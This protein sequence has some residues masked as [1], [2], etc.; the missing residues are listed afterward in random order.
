MATKNDVTQEELKKK[1]IYYPEEGYFIW[2]KLGNV[3]GWTRKD[4]YSFIRLNNKLYRTHRL[5]W[6]YMYGSF[7]K[8]EIDHIDGNPNNNR[9]NNLRL[10]NSTQNKC[11]TRL[12]KDSTSGAKGIH[13]YKAYEKWQVKLT[14]NKKT[15]NLGYFKDFFEACCVVASER[16]KIHKEFANHGS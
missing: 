8:N 1:L 3:A 14:Y 6:L 11:N 4:G 7:P 15:I 16:N 12:R 10:S 2:S 9:I 5:A 13:W